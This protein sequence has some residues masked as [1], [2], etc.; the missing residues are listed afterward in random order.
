M[1]DGI[2]QITIQSK[3]AH[4]S[5]ESMEITYRGSYRQFVGKH[6]IS[7][8]EY[9][10]EAA[11]SPAKSTNLMKIEK[12]AI[13][14]TKKGAVTTQMYFEKGK[15]HFGSYQTPFGNFDMVIYTEKLTVKE[16]EQTVTADIIYQLSL[17]GSHVSKCK[18]RMEICRNSLQS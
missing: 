8:E 12:N 10:E 15:K 2:V 17:N 6:I 18:L 5:D 3:Q 14:I 11:S 4:I 16:T 13:Q 9:F 7:Y 1:T